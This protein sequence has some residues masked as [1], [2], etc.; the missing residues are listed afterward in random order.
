[1]RTGKGT[2]TG[3]IALTMM[4]LGVTLLMSTGTVMAF[5][6]SAV[7]EGSISD[8]DQ[9]GLSDYEECSGI[10]LACDYI[11]S[12]AGTFD[13]FPG[14][15]SGLP[16]AQRLDPETQDLFVALILSSPPPGR[17]YSP[18]TEILISPSHDPLE[19]VSKPVAQGGLGVFPH[20][21]A[22]VCAGLGRSITTNQKAAFITESLSTSDTILGVAQYGTPNGPDDAIIY[23]QNIINH[24]DGVCSGTYQCKDASGVAWNPATAGY[25]SSGGIL[26][27]LKV[28]YMKH[29][30]A[31]ELGHMVNLRAGD[32]L[33]ELGGHHYPA[34]SNLVLD[35]NVVYDSVKSKGK[36]T[37]TFRITDDFHPEDLAG[38]VISGY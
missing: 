16:R 36:L 19:L 2:D 38:K 20:R 31:H 24:V 28:L 22:G 23:T 18:L 11:P 5:D 26:D 35:Q 21:I 27:P 14:S 1:M 15:A 25:I 6:C 37:V 10:A 17:T 7:G 3:I 29:T 8:Y 30:I 12:T 32:Y 9:D 4:V 13:F 33:P 34:G